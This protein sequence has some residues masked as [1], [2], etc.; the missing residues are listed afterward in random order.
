[1]GQHRA[2]RAPGG[3]RGVEDRGQIAPGCAARGPGRR[4]AAAI[5]AANCRRRR[6]RQASAP[7]R[8]SG[9]HRR[10]RRGA[11]GIAEKQPQA[12]HCRGN[13]PPRPAYRPCSAAGT[14]PPPPP[15]RHR[16]PAPRRF[17]HLHRHPVA[18]LHPGRAQRMR[19]PR[20]SHGRPRPR[21]PARRPRIKSGPPAPGQR[22]EK[23]VMKRV[24]HDCPPIR[25]PGIRLLPR[26]R[27]AGSQVPETVCPRCPV[28]AALSVMQCH[29]AARLGARN[30]VVM[31]SAQRRKTHGKSPEFPAGWAFP[32]WFRKGPRS[33]PR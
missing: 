17:R 18:R 19:P 5:A 10:Q 11:L 31:R 21:S 9:R 24:R 26:S 4:A 14:P 2:L 20:S 23:R 27:G 8:R 33:R 13:S 25:C 32:A 6:H 1:M 28:K 7:L 29:K 12:S 16:P 3:A 15:P 22:R 30:L